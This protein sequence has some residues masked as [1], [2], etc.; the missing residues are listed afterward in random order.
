MFRHTTEAEIIDGLDQLGGVAD[1]L[2]LLISYVDKNQRYR[3]NNLS[4]QEWFG[5]A[6]ESF[7]GKH[8]REIMGDEVYAD[9]LP[10]IKQALAGELAI[11]KGHIHHNGGKRFVNSVYIP[12]RD[13]NNVVVGFLV[14]IND[15]SD[16]QQA[17]EELQKNEQILLNSKNYLEDKVHERTHEL[18]GQKT[19]LQELNTALKVLVREREQD[20]RDIENQVIDNLECLVKPYIE[21]LRKTGLNKMQEGLVDLMTEN[22]NEIVSPYVRTLNSRFLHLTPA[23]LQVA[24]MVKRGMT[25]KGIASVMNLSPETINIHRKNIRRKCGLNN[26][27]TNLRT[28][29]MTLDD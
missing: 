6:R 2:S 23:E 5:R 29:L 18:E 10:G 15:L 12:S 1:A 21:K 17:F 11:F 22:L 8:V 3:F 20:K 24:A 4:Y 13:S 7:T 27:K 9:I 28:Y 26:T 25:S 16:S 19:Q 14:V